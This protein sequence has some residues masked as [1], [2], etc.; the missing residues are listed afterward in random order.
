[1]ARIALRI[2]TL[3]GALAV[4][5]VYNTAWAG[6]TY[7]TIASTQPPANGVSGLLGNPVINNNGEV[8]FVGEGLH[9][10]WLLV[11]CKSAQPKATRFCGNDDADTYRPKCAA[12]FS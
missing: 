2:L 5:T 3:A 4:V 8:A 9:K 12:F 7:T 11:Q 10:C 6:W 1:M